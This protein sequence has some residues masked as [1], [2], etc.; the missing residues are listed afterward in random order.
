MKSLSLTVPGRAYM[1]H[2]RTAIHDVS[3]VI[4]LHIFGCREEHVAIYVFYCLI[5]ICRTVAIRAIS[6]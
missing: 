2:S 5:P 6:W 1:D 4:G 3:L